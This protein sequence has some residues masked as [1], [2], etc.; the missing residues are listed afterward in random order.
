[1]TSPTVRLLVDLTQTLIPLEK[2][3]QLDISNDCLE[4]FL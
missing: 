4:G 3:L 2:S 1:M